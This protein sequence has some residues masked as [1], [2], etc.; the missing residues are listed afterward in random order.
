MSPEEAEAHYREAIAEAGE[1]E[2]RVRRYY[3]LG[4]S[5][6]FFEVKVSA[7]VSGYAEKDLVGPAQQGDVRVIIIYSDLEAKQFPLPIISGDKVLVDGKELSVI[8]PDAATRRIG[9][10]VVAYDLVTR[11]ASL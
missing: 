5:R 6:T 3:N 7:K 8:A 2:V 4:P 11:G 1:V 10:V 9:G